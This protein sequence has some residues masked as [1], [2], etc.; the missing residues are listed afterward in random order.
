MS[1]RSGKTCQPPQREWISGHGLAS[2][3][4]LLIHDG[5]HSLDEYPAHRGW[6]HSSLPDALTFARRCEV[7]QLLLFHHDPWHDDAFLE[8][9]GREAAARWAQLG[10]EGRV[11]LSREGAVVD[12]D[13]PAGGDWS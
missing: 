2:G 4:S 1:P 3:A 7:Q 13:A 12:L 10:G 9:L 5:Q 6:G 11:E 8:A